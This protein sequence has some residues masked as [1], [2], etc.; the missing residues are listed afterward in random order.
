MNRD[1][2]KQGRG[3]E[4]STRTERIRHAETEALIHSR[5][6][7]A[8]R[9]ERSQDYAETIA[10][11]IHTSG[12]ARAIDIARRMGVSH[13]TVAKI[14]AR[15]QRE[16]L[17]TTQPY[18]SIFLTPNGRKVAEQA[19]RRHDLVL[20]FLVA[21]GVKPAIAAIDAEGIEHHVSDETLAVFRRF[22]RLY[23]KRRAK[24]QLD[25]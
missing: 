9:Q 12:E 21:I 25:R 18:R 3:A 15:M 17:V 8:H 16:G 22:I 4:K 20:E 19:R 13:V 1:N 11:L 14:I 23:G 6:R 7:S 24:G 5:T 2:R 10:D